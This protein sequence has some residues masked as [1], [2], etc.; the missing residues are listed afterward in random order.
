M[1]STLV[2]LN[3][4]DGLSPDVKPIQ[5]RLF[6]MAGMY[7][8]E[9]ARLTIVKN[10]DPIVYEFH[11]LGLPERAGAIAYGTSITYAGRAG[12]EYC[13][14]IES[15]GFRKLVVDRDGEP[16]IRDNPRWKP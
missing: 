16:E 14:T 1:L 7:A 13:G 3:L 12:D 15:R 4:H 8:D 9:D 5:R 6:A 10:G 11:D 2:K